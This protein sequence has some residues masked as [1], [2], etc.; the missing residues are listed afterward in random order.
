MMAGEKELAGYQGEGTRRKQR[1]A[2]QQE[3]TVY[4]VADQGRSVRAHVVECSRRGLGLQMREALPQGATVLLEWRGAYLAAAVTACERE[5]KRFGR[6]TYR[7]RLIVEPTR[8]AWLVLD[9]IYRTGTAPLV[10]SSAP[11]GPRTRLVDLE[12]KHLVGAVG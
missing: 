8:A 10:S 7:C 6:G 1:P 12:A 3:L 9:E 5:E 4:P 11:S 2:Q